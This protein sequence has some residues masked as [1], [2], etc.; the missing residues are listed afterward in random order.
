MKMLNKKNVDGVIF[1][2]TLLPSAMQP[3]KFTLKK[4]TI[5]GVAAG[6]PATAQI[7]WTNIIFTR[8]SPPQQHP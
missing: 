4:G 2:P 6:G 1:G 8:Q 5:F 7:F 3:P